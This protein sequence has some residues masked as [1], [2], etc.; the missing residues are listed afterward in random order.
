MVSARSPRSVVNASAPR[1]SSTVSRSSSAGRIGEASRSRQLGLDLAR[2]LRELT[3]Q[4]DRRVAVHVFG[5]SQSLEL[6][7]LRVERPEELLR[8]CESLV[9]RSRHAASS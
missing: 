7:A 2:E 4:V 6:L 3:D 5:R 9:D 8:A 1:Y